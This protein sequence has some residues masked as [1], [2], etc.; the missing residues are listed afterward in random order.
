MSAKDQQNSSQTQPAISFG[1][2]GGR[3]MAQVVTVGATGTLT[4]IGLQN[5]TCPAVTPLSILVQRL[6]VAGLPDGTSIAT[7]SATT[8][9]NAITV[10][11]TVNMAIGEKFAFIVSSPVACTFINAA[12]TDQYNAGDAYVDP[13]S[14]W[15]SLFSTD[16]RYDLPSFRTLLQP[17]MPVGYLTNSARLRRHGDVAEQRNR[18]ADGDQRERRNLQSGDE[19]DARLAA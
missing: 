18:A 3:R 7:G 14:G 15:V 16:G 17:A 2:L 19:H 10:T 8:N 11:P 9:Y 1:G 12:T 4:G 13:G 5:I 6:T